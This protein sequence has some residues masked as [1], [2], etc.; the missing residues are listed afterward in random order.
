MVWSAQVMWQEIPQ[1]VSSYSCFETNLKSEYLK[2]LFEGTCPLVNKKVINTFPVSI[3]IK[4][5]CHR[6]IDLILTKE[7]QNIF[8]P[9]VHWD[10]AVVYVVQA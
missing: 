3:G 4:I 5:V 9:D 7:P 1:T 10:P 2:G 8:K 6:W